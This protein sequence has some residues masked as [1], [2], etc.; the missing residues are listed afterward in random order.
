MFS[1][2]F[3]GQR[4][5]LLR[6][7]WIGGGPV[8]GLLLIVAWF[9]PRDD[10]R[11]AEVT[12]DV[13]A[14]ADLPFYTGGLSTLGLLLWSASA[15]MCFLTYAVLRA[16]GGSPFVRVLGLGGAWTLLLLLDDAYM[17]HD[18]ILPGYLGLPGAILTGLYVA[19]GGGMALRYRA[20]LAR[21]PYL[22]ILLSLGA[23]GVSVGVDGLV[24]AGLYGKSGLVYLA[25]DGS[26]LIGIVFWTG[27]VAHTCGLALWGR[28]A[29]PGEGRMHAEAAPTGNGLV[30]RRGVRVRDDEGELTV[31]RRHD[32]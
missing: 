4:S 9:A 14:I 10:F 21:T 26:K 8:L 15:A 2:R 31:S 22:L 32:E 17:L 3:D 12:R 7:L 29:A 24:D 11:V 23:L 28:G 19:L 30:I 25:E 27:Y 5:P 6:T 1:F 18:A 13:Q 16:G 20:I